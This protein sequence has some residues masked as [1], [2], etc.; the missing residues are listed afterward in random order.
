MTRARSGG[1]TM[2]RLMPRLVVLLA[3][4]AVTVLMAVS[5]ARADDPSSVPIPTGPAPVIGENG[6]PLLNPDGS[7]KMVDVYETPTHDPE[8]PLLELDPVEEEIADAPPEPI[9]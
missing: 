1:W 5:L 6:Q 8:P 4:V 3:V 7:P 2:S 9:P